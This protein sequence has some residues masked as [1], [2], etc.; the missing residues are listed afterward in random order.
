MLIFNSWLKDIKM[1]IQGWRLSHLEAVQLIKD[2]TS[3]N[4]NG[5]VEFYLDTNSTWNYK[6]LKEHLQTSFEMGKC[7][8]SLQILSRK[9]PSIHPEWK[10]EVNKVLKTQFSFQLCDPYL[11]AM[12]HNFLKPQ[13]KDM[14]F[15]QFCDDCVFMFGFH[16]KTVKVSTAAHAIEDITS[17]KIGEQKKTHSQ[18]HAQKNK[19]KWQVQ[20][21]L[22]EQ[23][24]KMRN[25]KPLKPLGLPPAAYETHHTGYIMQIHGYKE[26]SKCAKDWRKTILRDQ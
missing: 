6:A 5:V 24:K 9:V 13:G 14:S 26:I 10:A 3:N 25:W 16:S 15:T 21:E 18:V 2:Y 17:V 22:T 11:A 19:K 8:S 7:F 12:A 23:Q 20:T 1:C 4:V